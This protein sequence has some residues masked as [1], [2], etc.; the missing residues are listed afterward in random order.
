MNFMTRGSAPPRY[1]LALEAMVTTSADAAQLSVQPLGHRRI[2][3]LCR[4]ARAVAEVSARLS[5]PLGVVRLLVTDLAEAGLVTVAQPET[6][7][8]TDGGPS[9]EILLRVLDALRDGP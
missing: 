2:C 6:H 9:P 8:G 7:T 4:E 3:A 1:R 5:M